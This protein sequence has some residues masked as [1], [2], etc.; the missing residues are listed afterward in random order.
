MKKFLTSVIA[1][2]ICIAGFSQ[3][4][5]ANKFAFIKTGE[6]VSQVAACDYQINLDLQK[7]SYALID[8]AN[9]DTLEVVTG[10]IVD[11]DFTFVND[12]IIVTGYKGTCS[13]GYPLT[14]AFSTLKK[15][16][17]IFR[18]GLGSE[19]KFYIFELYKPE[20]PNL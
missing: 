19:S 7:H 8:R 17:E 16:G 12:S 6:A 15:T 20:I 4:F 3:T 10:L 5:Y 2:L 18:A 14:V 13:H 1:I 11:K 9:G